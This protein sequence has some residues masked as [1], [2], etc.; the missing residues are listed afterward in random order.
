MDRNMISK[1]HCHPF[2]RQTRDF[3]FVAGKANR[4]KNFTRPCSQNPSF[5]FNPRFPT[6][7]IIFQ[8]VSSL[9]R[10]KLSLTWKNLDISHFSIQFFFVKF[11]KFNNFSTLNFVISSA[12]FSPFFSRKFFYKHRSIFLVFLYPLKNTSQLYF[13]LFHWRYII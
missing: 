13:S 11:A 1:Y 7:C 3:E 5:R 8:F 6:I 10:V 12:I 9:I 4:A 2:V